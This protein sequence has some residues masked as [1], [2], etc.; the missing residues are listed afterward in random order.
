MRYAT[1]TPVKRSAF[2]SDTHVFT[3]GETARLDAA[4]VRFKMVLSPIALL[5]FWGGVFGLASAG[6]A[7]IR[8]FDRFHFLILMLFA[9]IVEIA[10]M[11]LYAVARTL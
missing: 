4:L 1:F 8:F 3:S 2:Y 11:T 7:Y 6:R 5:L 9:F 10:L